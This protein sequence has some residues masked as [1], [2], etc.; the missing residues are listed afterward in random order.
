MIPLR[1]RLHNFMSYG[2]EGGDLDLRTIHLACLSGSNGHGKSTLI[3]ALTWALWGCSRAPREDDLVRAGTTDMEVEFEFA[4][5]GSRYRVI[6]KRAVRKSS[7]VADL[8]LAVWD[9]DAYKAI[10]G[11]TIYETE[12]VIIELLGLTY[13]TFINSSLL[14]QGKADLFTVKPPRERKAVLAEIL[15][16]G[17]YDKLAERAREQERHAREAGERLA[18]RIGELDA[19]LITLPGIREGIAACE[20]DLAAQQGTRE[21]I[22]TAVQALDGQVRAAQGLLEQIAAREK[23]VREVEADQVRLERERADALRREEQA[24]A[25]LADEAQVRRQ[26]E[27]LG[28]LRAEADRLGALAIDAHALEREKHEHEQ[29]IVLERKRLEDQIGLRQQALREATKAAAEI[30]SIQGAVAHIGVELAALPALDERSREWRRAE[31]ALN[32]ALSE[33][34]VN[35]KA[36]AAQVV[37]QRERYKQLHSADAACPVCGAPLTRE[38]RERIEHELVEEGKRLKEQIEEWEA[39]RARLCA[40][41]EAGQKAARAH[42][43]EIEHLRKLRIQEAG[44]AERLRTLHQLAASVGT[45]QT[46][47]DRLESILAGGRFA[48]EA[49]AAI[50]V[51]AERLAALHYDSA[52]HEEV[53]RR[54]VALQPCEVRLAALESAREEATR[55]GM[56]AEA[57]LTL[58]KEREAE[59]AR[60][61]EECSS[62]RA[63]IG[64][65][66]AVRTALAERRQELDAAHQSEAVLQRRLGGLRRQ[67][68]E[69]ERRLVEREQAE[70]ARSAAMERETAM[71]ELAL[72]FGRNGIP[73]MLIENALPE[74][75]QD[76]NELL[77]RMTDNSTQVSFLTQR[78]GKSGKAIE[79]LDIKIADSAGTRPYEM[80]SGGEA[81]RINLAIR[82]AL[83]RLL[84]RRAGAELRFLL[85]DEGFGTQDA[86]GRDRLVEAIAAIAED[87]DKILVVT[88]IE[89]LKERFDVQIEVT[90]GEAGSRVVVARA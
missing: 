77:S 40:D 31:A 28:R 18:E 90:K 57:R 41:L 54:V 9:N 15:E 61:H 37:K 81:F 88:H 76:A 59:L 4:C 68:E 71:K 58:L 86:Q 6:R 5:R 87:F 50:Q 24:R 27:E 26:V 74:L 69:G 30:E 2:V 80:F 82:I 75:E 72:A 73:A 32:A 29:T 39:A 48:G 67:F 83:S 43:C 25:L 7:S 53:R 65:L 66:A 36:G 79:T 3:D 16:L 33:I 64:D 21:T 12:R 85:I 34:T 38:G 1:L 10:T 17:L 46:E 51:T 78:Q 55:A 22:E 42:E 70:T 63:Q 11:A 89:E 60:L 44:Y 84:A 35:S 23:R 14:L 62:L 8:Q 20:T 19:I 13:E 52:V 45:E 56:E 47:L 49:R